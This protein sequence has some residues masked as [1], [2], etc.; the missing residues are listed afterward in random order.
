MNNST[1]LLFR[2]LVVLFLV[3]VLAQVFL[4]GLATV[5]R[6]AQYGW[7]LH[8]A[9]GH[10]LA[11]L[12]IPMLIVTYLGKAASQVKLLT[13]VLFLVWVIQV[14]ALIIFLRETAPFLAA[15]HPVL[16]LVDFGLGLRLLAV[17]KAAAPDN[18]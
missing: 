2:V 14:Y 7:Q 15:L 6:P 13:W 12:L 4:A 17:T 10:G 8:S 3:T 9:L 18:L 16:A 5:P 11:V 1:N